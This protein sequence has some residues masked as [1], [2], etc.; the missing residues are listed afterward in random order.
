MRPQDRKRRIA[1]GEEEGE[2][3]MGSDAADEV[4]SDDLDE[5]AQVG[6]GEG[7]CVCWCVCGVCCGLR[8]CAGELRCVLSVLAVRFRG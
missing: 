1:A 7:V 4:E 2:E 8:A 3:G 6:W 5:L